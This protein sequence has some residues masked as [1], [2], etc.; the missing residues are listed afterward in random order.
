M[1]PGRSLSFL[2]TALLF[3][4]AQVEAAPVKQPPRMIT[5]P[6]KRVPQ[7][8]GIPPSVVSTTQ[9]VFI[10]KETFISTMPPPA[11]ATA[12]QP[13]RTPTCAN[14]RPSG[15]FRLR[16]DEAIGEAIISGEIRQKV[17]PG[18]CEAEPS[19]KRRGCQ[20]QIRRSACRSRVSVSSRS[21]FLHCSI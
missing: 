2:L 4:L 19:V 16:A 10:L 1:Q 7:Q 20:R 12:Y 5:M 21:F 18:W 17:Q 14:E 9:R 3:A 6:L 15:P 8:P 11:F 13:K